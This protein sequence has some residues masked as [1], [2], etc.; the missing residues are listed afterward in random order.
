MRLSRYQETAG[1]LGAVALGLPCWRLE[2][3][4]NSLSLSP[5]PLRKESEASLGFLPGSCKAAE[6]G[7]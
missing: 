2:Q 5:E 7:S 3:D 1:I 4:R 6:T